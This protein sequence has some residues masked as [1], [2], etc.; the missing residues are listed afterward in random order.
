MIDTSPDLRYQLLQL[1]KTPHIDAILY[2]HEHFDHTFGIG[3]LRPIFYYRNELVPIYARK[4]VLDYIKNV[5][6]FMLFNP[7][8]ETIYK[9]T[10]RAEEIIGDSF[11]IRKG[12][13]AVEVTCIDMQHGILGCTGYRIENFAYATDV[14]SF[15]DASLSKLLNLDVLIVDCLSFERDSKAH[16]NLKQ[17]LELVDVVKPKR[18][19]LTHMDF[20][21]DYDTLIDVLPKNIQPAYDGLTIEI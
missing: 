13:D 11:T 15:S 4:K 5:A 9:P 6:E 8:G 7:S 3:D 21:M 10:L 12:S 19:F 14:S 1:E 17:V 2:T 20:S 16:M 18:T